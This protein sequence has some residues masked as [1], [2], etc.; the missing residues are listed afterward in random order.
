MAVEI[1]GVKKLAVTFCNVPAETLNKLPMASNNPVTKVGER[2]FGNIKHV[3]AFPAFKELLQRRPVTHAHKKVTGDDRTNVTFFLGE[4]TR[5]DVAQELLLEL[6]TAE[7]GKGKDEVVLHTAFN[8]F[9]AW[10]NP[11]ESIGLVFIGSMK[12]RV[13]QHVLHFAE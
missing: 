8:F 12:S 7:D 1:S 13:P 2:I 6:L 3:W 11:D 4:G 10:D 5:D 9:H